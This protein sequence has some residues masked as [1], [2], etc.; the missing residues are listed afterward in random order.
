MCEGD[1]NKRARSAWADG[2]SHK[3]LKSLSIEGMERAWDALVFTVLELNYDL[4]TGWATADSEGCREFDVEVDERYF[5]VEHRANVVVTT[6]RLA[7]DLAVKWRLF[8]A[9]SNLDI[10]RVM[11]CVRRKDFLKSRRFEA[12]PFEGQVMG[13]TVNGKSQTS[14]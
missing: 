13:I 8:T 7:L 10:V 4:K 2:L 6:V 3:L 5:W 12:F 1:P 14:A 11:D 9:D